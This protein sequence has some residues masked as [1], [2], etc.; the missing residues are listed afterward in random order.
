MAMKLD[1]DALAVKPN[2]YTTT[3][4]YAYIVY[5]LNDMIC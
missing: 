1:K 4:V 2:N 3:V 5:D